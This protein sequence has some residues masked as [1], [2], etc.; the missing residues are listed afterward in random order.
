MEYLV[1]ESANADG[2]SFTTYRDAISEA[3]RLA[4]LQSDPVYIDTHDGEELTDVY[5]TVDGSGKVIK[6][7]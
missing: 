1:S 6:H 3:K 4:K 5:Y 7:K 2:Q